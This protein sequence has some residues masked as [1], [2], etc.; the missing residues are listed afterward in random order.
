MAKEKAVR[1]YKG[2]TK[3]ASAVKSAKSQPVYSM[4]TG[5]YVQGSVKT[6]TKV[7]SYKEKRLQSTSAVMAP[8]TKKR[9][10]QMTSIEKMDA[11]R[12]GISK[13]ALEELKDK[14]GLIMISFPQF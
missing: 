10:S 4:M 9:E 5:R 11:T 3:G 2:G 12:Q 7:Q 14:V 6:G 1:D 8:V 13:K